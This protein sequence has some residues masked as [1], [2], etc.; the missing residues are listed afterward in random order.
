[1]TTLNPLPRLAWTRTVWG[2]YVVDLCGH[3][4]T[5]APYSPGWVLRI[6]GSAEQSPARPYRTLAEA[7]GAAARY[8]IK[9]A[10]VDATRI[11]RG[12]AS[13]VR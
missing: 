10:M 13:N 2:G 7:K 9:R 6:D 8:A 1:M 4:Y 5:L 12:G 3:R 11:A